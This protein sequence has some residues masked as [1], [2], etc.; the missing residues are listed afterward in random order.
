MKSRKKKGPSDEE[1]FT[2]LLEKILNE[3]ARRIWE[4]IKEK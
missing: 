4:K 2:L 1:L 3:R